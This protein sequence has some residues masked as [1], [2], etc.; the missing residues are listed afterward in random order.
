MI[1]NQVYLIK[2]IFLRGITFSN[3]LQQYKMGVVC[4]QTC[5]HGHDFQRKTNHSA[6]VR[7]RFRQQYL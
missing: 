7:Q 4:I 6:F 1:K 2:I 3:N 5:A